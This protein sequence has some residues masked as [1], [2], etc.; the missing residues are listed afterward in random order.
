M[1]SQLQ[2][3]IEQPR[4]V[5][6]LFPPRPRSNTNPLPVQQ[7]C[8][9]HVATALY[10]IDAKYKISWECAELLIELG[11]TGSPSSSVS[12]PAIPQSPQA[13]DAGRGRSVT[14]PGVEGGLPASSTPVA[15]S[16]SGPAQPASV[17]RHDLSQ[18]QLALLR[19]M[20][21]SSIVSTVSGEG[22]QPAAR[23]GDGGSLVDREWRWGDAMNSTVTLPPSDGSQ[24]DP[25]PA[26]KRESR[27]GMKG[28]RDMLRGLKRNH[29]DPP[30]TLSTDEMSFSA[31]SSLD[32]NRHRHLHAHPSRRTKGS[33]GP[34]ESV[35]SAMGPP[36]VPT[37]AQE[38]ATAPVLSASQR[39]SPRRPSIASIFRL[40][41][42]N[43]STTPTEAST[44]T[45]GALSANNGQTMTTSA[46]SGSLGGDEDWDWDQIEGEV[47]VDSAANTRAAVLDN[48]AAPTLRGRGRLL[49]QQAPSDRT[50]SGSN[51]FKRATSASHVPIQTHHR[52]ARLSNVD[53]GLDQ[54][55]RSFLPEGKFKMPTTVPLRKPSLHR[56]AKT[57]T[58]RSAPVIADPPR[59]L[60]PPLVVGPPLAMTPENIKPLLENA[61]EVHARLVDCVAE[62]R[63]LLVAQDI[64][65]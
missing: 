25:L 38:G 55:Q 14:L 9:A 44:D 61:K 30:P 13:A 4:A 36:S 39:S 11:G 56:R 51:V 27:L 24:D 8:P 65:S 15:Q 6:P 37:Q 35:R 59:S 5:S 12:A 34:A 31:E 63:E 16:G 46:S 17:G 7:H 32:R 57:S 18:R 23:D 3:R 62:V 28:L 42:R 19:E 33:T 1:L 60:P 43:K 2:P 45:S 53:E 49:N 22:E 50:D 29:T 64:Q 21:E 54:R 40:G 52:P 10:M 26:K 48:S 20:L 58:V 47:D 41:L